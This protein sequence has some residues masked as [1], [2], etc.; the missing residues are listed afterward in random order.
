[1]AGRQERVDLAT[2]IESA[3]R[4]SIHPATP[5][6]QI[7]ISVRGRT[8]AVRRPVTATDEGS[9]PSLG[10]AKPE[11]QTGKAAGSNPVIWG[12]ES[13][14]VPAPALCAGWER[15]PHGT[16][17]HPGSARWRSGTLRTTER[18]SNPPGAIPAA[19]DHQPWWAGTTRPPGPRRPGGTGRRAGLRHR[20]PKGRGGSSPSVGTLAADTGSPSSDPG[21][22][23]HD[24]GVRMPATKPT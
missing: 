21:R 5:V 4:L 12:F 23:D 7:F 16:W 14:S 15:V 1:M 20:C 17:P 24:E 2:G 9:N 18:A 8:T 13:S 3:A 19:T 11:Q 10:A 6:A 22:L